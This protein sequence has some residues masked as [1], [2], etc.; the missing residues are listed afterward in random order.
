[1][2]LVPKTLCKS[3]NEYSIY[4]QQLLD[5]IKPGDIVFLNG[6]IGAGK[7]TF[8]QKVGELLNIKA[9]ITSPTFNIV[10]TYDD[11]LCHIDGYRLDQEAIDFE[12]YRDDYYIFIEWNECLGNLL[13]PQYIINITYCENGRM[14]EIIK[15]E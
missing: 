12:Y 6:N 4:A 15:E 13:K 8:V 9:K 5:V 11:K 14:L 7:T 3:P 10:K 1:M 2:I